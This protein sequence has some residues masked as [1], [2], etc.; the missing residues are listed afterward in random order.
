VALY[1]ERL[2]ETSDSSS[3]TVT[4]RVA[5]DG[6]AI[7]EQLER[8]LAS[9]SF[10]A[11]KR[12][13]ALLAYVVKA[14]L[15][16]N[17]EPVKER[18]L[19]VEVFHRDPTYDTSSDSVVRTTA[20]EIRK[21]LA[22][23]YYDPSHADEIRIELP[24]GSYVPEFYIGNSDH[25]KIE[26]NPSSVGLSGIPLSSDVAQQQPKQRILSAEKLRKYSKYIVP[27]IFL[28]GGVILG[29]SISKLHPSAKMSAF[30]EFWRPFV[31][32]PKTV[33][34]CMGELY[35]TELHY[36]PNQ[37]RSRLSGIFRIRTPGMGEVPVSQEEDAVT[38]ARISAVLQSRNKAYLIRGQASTT[39]SDLKQGPSILIGSYENDWSIHGTDQLR[40]YF[41]ANPETRE[42]WIG[43]HQ[44]P[45][46][47]VGAYT[48]GLPPLHPMDRYAIISRFYD[49]TTEQMTLIVGGNSRAMLSAAEFI[50][51][52]TYLEDFA[53]HAPQNWSTKNMQ[54][55]IA[56]A[57]M[58]GS[59]EPPRVVAFYVW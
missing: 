39:F 11:S 31:A 55:I 54:I 34:I 58:D 14:A 2:T 7:R 4:R 30:D 21:R 22:Q 1:I 41:D 52:P 59:A 37:M 29:A 49:P 10:A 33:L 42:L 44:K 23:Y 45:N 35:T 53:K 47:K 13:S 8:V 18:T 38:L 48:P 9:P 46:E 5:I 17:P 16:D 3:K 26:T 32:S 40:Y 51:N 19:G 43:D 12:C 27:L 57:V 6:I 50:A 25:N 28:L 36:S 56:S 24:S 15:R 20:G